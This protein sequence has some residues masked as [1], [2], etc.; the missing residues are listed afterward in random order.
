[1]TQL[2]CLA[3]SWKHQDRCIAGIEPSTGQWI[4]PVSDLFDGRIPTYQALIDGEEIE[5]LDIIEIPLADTGP[6]F[7]FASE[8]RLILPGEWKK[9]GRVQITDLSN[10]GHASA[11][12]LHT[13][14]KYV[15]RSFMQTLPQSQRRTLQLVYVVEFSLDTMPRA[16]GGFSWKGTLVTDTGQ[17]LSQLTITDPVLVQRLRHEHGFY[18]KPPFWATISLSMPHIP[19]DWDGPTDPCWKIIAA[20]ILPSSADWILIEMQRLGWSIH[21]G[22]EYL[23][24]MYGKRSRRQ[25]TDVEL[26]Q[27][28]DYLKSLPTVA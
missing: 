25:L 14:K 23:Q 13:C 18:P 16:E 27:F 3:N 9:V 11:P 24:K 28:L 19:L 21:Q 2:I 10:Y 22:Q 12:I 7:G 6:D 20:V 17:R 1:M 26:S 15:T 8:N 5:L 4:R